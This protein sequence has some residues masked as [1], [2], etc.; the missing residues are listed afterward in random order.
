MHTYSFEIASHLLNFGWG[1]RWSGGY[2][3]VHFN[4]YGYKVEGKYPSFV[5]LS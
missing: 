3:A 5:Y 2:I 4:V 1:K